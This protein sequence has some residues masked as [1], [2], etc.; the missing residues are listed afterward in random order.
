MAKTDALPDMPATPAK[1]KRTETL[2]A[3]YKGGANTFSDV[4]VFGTKLEA[5]EFAIEQDPPWKVAA[6]V[7]GQRLSE[8]V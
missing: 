6:I 4:V 3:A 1:P 8:A 7:K 2:H 5:Y